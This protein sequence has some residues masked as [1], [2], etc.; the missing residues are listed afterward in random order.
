MFISYFMSDKIEVIVFD[1]GGVL[2]KTSHKEFY[3][4]LDR[5][6]KEYN[7]DPNI[8]ERLR[9]KYSKSSS[10]G[11]LSDEEFK[12]RILNELGVKNKGD[13]TE[14]WDNSLYQCMKINLGVYFLIS[15]LKK[16]YIIVSFSN[17]TPMFHKIRLKNKVYDLFHLNFLSHQYGLKKPSI[18]FYKT[19]IKKVD[20]PT[21]RMIFVD[22]REENLVPAKK[23]GMKVIL[24]KNNKQLI[25]DLKKLGI[26]I[27]N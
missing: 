19:L 24:F 7:I 25:G 22:D 2:T 21:N 20:V 3:L 13:F 17:V 10:L 18:N 12:R 11:K 27:N 4:K 23:L 26:K 16:N 14:K 6:A 9:I 15:K 5:L 1:I 8:F